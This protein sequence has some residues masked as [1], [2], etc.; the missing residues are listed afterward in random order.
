MGFDPFQKKV[1]L[2]VEPSL[3]AYHA[4]V[5]PKHLQTDACASPIDPSSTGG[6]R[7]RKHEGL[8]S[9]A[10]PLAYRAVSFK[11]ARQG[12]EPRLTDSKSVVLSI[13]LA[14][15]TVKNDLFS[16]CPSQESNLVLDLRRVACV[17]V[18]LQGP[19]SLVVRARFELADTG[20]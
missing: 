2:G 12:V 3:P 8:S 20:S 16:Q 10:L 13:T 4:G 18:T 14:G 15:Q 6:S 17:S 9:V 5:L 11:V 1:C 7:T 19:G